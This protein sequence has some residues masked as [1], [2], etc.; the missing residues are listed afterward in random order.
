MDRTLKVINEMKENGVIRDYAIG[1]AIAVMFYTEPFV[2][3][4]LDIIFIPVEEEKNRLDVLSSIYAYLQGRGYELYDEYIIVEGV[5]VQ[6]MPVYNELSLEAVIN[7]DDVMYEDVRTRVFKP[8]YL[9]ALYVLSDRPRK[10]DKEK[11]AKLFEQHEIDEDL[12]E[13]ILRRHGLYEKY[14]RNRRR[15]YY[16]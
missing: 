7:A 3:I 15:G 10:H 12:L 13:N 14:I 6:F 5:T 16:D 8:E 1:G 2:T 4:D 9:I 11:V